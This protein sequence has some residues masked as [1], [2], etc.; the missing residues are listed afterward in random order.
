MG[1]VS[2]QWIKYLVRAVCPGRQTKLTGNADFP[3]KS[4]RRQR[5]NGREKLFFKG[6]NSES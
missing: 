3:V 4:K 5:N 2:K 1:L 6:Q